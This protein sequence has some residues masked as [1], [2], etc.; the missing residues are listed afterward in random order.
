MI[1]SFDIEIAEDVG[2]NSAILFTNIRFWCLKNKANN[3]N[4]HDG[5]YWTYN[6][7][8]AWSEL[9]PYIG[10]SAIKTALKKLE[11]KEYIV[12][13][14]YNKSSYDRT[15]W[16]SLFHWS[17]IANGKEGNSQ[18]IPDINTDTNKNTKISKYEQ[19]IITLK[20]QVKNPS[21]VTS[22]KNGRKFFGS[23]KSVD[24]LIAAYISH[25]EEKDGFASVITKFMEDYISNQNNIVDPN[26]KSTW[27]KV[28]V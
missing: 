10:E 23:V 2:V 25:Q 12:T 3:T 27:E 19:F 11:D 21:K 20:E 13:G 18:P 26:D 16:F 15:R 24:L 5:R 6:S 8:R 14:N 17:K 1:H 22:T 4:L 9:F 28:E 7:A